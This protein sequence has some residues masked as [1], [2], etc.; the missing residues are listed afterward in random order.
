MEKITHKII[1]NVDE[2][3]VQNHNSSTCFLSTGL[4]LYQA[5]LFHFNQE[6]R[7]LYC[8]E[9]QQH[10]NCPGQKDP[11]FRITARTSKYADVYQ[12][13]WTF[14]FFLCARWLLYLHYLILLSGKRKSSTTIPAHGK[15]REMLKGNQ[16]GWLHLGLKDFLLCYPISLGLL[17]LPHHFLL[18]SLYMSWGIVRWE[19]VRDSKI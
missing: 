2:L 17:T 13:F 12:D 19:E 3:L 8:W 11:C 7:R 10:V 4:I 5:V 14:I 6:I 9:S 1:F 16:S 18:L 15:D